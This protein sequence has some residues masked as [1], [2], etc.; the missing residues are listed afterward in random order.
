M[1]EFQ[2]F[3]R[4][5]WKRLEILDAAMSLADLAGLPSN[6]LEALK[7]DRAGQYSVRINQQWRIC[8]EWAASARGP[9]HVEI[10]DYH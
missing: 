6:R 5:G 3:D 8:F 7:G 2:S 4:Q 10:V 1:R 9:S